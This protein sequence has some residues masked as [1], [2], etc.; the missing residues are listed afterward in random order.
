L[1]LDKGG[2]V[3]TVWGR[4]SEP[5]TLDDLQRTFDQVVSPSA[6]AL[7]EDDDV[8]ESAEPVAGLGQV[9]QLTEH[10]PEELDPEE[11]AAL[12]RKRPLGFAAWPETA[13]ER[14]ER[15]AAGRMSQREIEELPEHELARMTTDVG[16][17]TL[18]RRRDWRDDG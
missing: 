9:T 6:Y 16:D 1:S 2:E 8:F 17:L 4:T 18:D 13:Q 3:R 14:L 15:A 12:K 11:R 7:P 10:S 5:L